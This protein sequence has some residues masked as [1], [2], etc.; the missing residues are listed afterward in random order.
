MEI[1][2]G[3][4]LNEERIAPWVE[5]VNKEFNLE[6]YNTASITYFKNIKDLCIFVDDKDFYICLLTNLDMWGKISLGVMSL[7]I[8]P[9]KRSLRQLNIINKIIE[10]IAISNNCQYICQGSHLDNRYLK[11]L[12]RKG[13]VMS[14]MRKDLWATL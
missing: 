2:K 6:E 9:E 13:Y 11:F 1:I 12:E 3:I 5:K 8:T 7:Y 4:D 14:G 10:D